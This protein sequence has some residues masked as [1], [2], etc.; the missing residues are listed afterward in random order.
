VWSAAGVGAG[1]HG[2]EPW[3]ASPSNI[4]MMRSSRSKLRTG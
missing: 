3:G 4:V 2:S 1:F